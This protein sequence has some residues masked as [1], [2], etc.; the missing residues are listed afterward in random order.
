MVDRA[1]KPSPDHKITASLIRSGCGA[2]AKHPQQAAIASDGI[3]PWEALA[4]WS[5]LLL[6]CPNS[7]HQIL[8]YGPNKRGAKSKTGLSKLIP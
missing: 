2:V 7:Y 8:S 4:F 5:V 1:T 3:D 6:G